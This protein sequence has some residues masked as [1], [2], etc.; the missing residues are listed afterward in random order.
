MI[1]NYV[2][3]YLYGP[4]SAQIVSTVHNNAVYQR[5]IIRLQPAQSRAQY[6]NDN[7]INAYMSMLQKENDERCKNTAGKLRCIIYETHFFP[8]LFDV[9]KT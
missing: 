9:G 4:D 6:L 5:D 3:K 8:R 2:R 1:H 7:I